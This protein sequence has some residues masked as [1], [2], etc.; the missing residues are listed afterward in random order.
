MLNFV[1][2]ILFAL[3]SFLFNENITIE[4]KECF[5]QPLGILN[6]AEELRTLVRN[7]KSEVEHPTDQNSRICPGN[8][9]I[10]LINWRK[11]QALP[12]GSVPSDYK[13]QP[14]FIKQESSIKD[15]VI[16]NLTTSVLIFPFNYF[17]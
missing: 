16:P 11:Y 4:K 7:E 8:S 12:S 5:P 14:K 1:R 3:I 10:R 13:F 9:Q 15:P 2:I 17:W 6:L